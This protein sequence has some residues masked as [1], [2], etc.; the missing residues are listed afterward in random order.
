MKKILLLSLSVLLLSV[1]TFAFQVTMVTDSG[2][3]GDQSFND[4]TWAGVEKAATELGI[5]SRVIQSHEQSDFVP[6]LSQAAQNSECVIAVGYMLEEALKAVAPQYPDTD[7]IG[8]DMGELGQPNIRTYSFKEQEG[9]FLAGFI[10]AAM[11]NTGIISVVGG[12]PIAPVQRYEIGYRAGASAYN[13]IHDADVQVLVGYVQSFIDVQKGKTMTV[14]QQSQGADITFQIA[15][16]SGLGVFEAVKSAGEGYYAIGADMDQDYLV[17]GRVLCSALKRIDNAAYYGI[18][19]SYED[20]FS[21]GLVT[22]GLVEDG[23]GIS[24][25]TYTRDKVPEHILLEISGIVY[26]AKT[27]VLK[28]PE[29]EEELERFVV[30]F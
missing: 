11:T 9:G 27:G 5:E 8:I 6:N 10:G 1:C 30:K 17:E 29:T 13:Q 21:G 18:K 4:G 26:S 24:P 14:S 15:G 22:L 12:I 16:L 19:D 28:I 25:M 20:F 3:L 2:G 23:I 7:F